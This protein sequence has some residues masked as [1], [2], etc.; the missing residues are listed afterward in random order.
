MSK[1]LT[2]LQ[3]IQPTSRSWSQWIDMAKYE[4]CC[5][6]GLSHEVQY[7]VKEMRNGKKKLFKRVR[8]NKGRTAQ[9]RKQQVFK[10][11]PV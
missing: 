3:F 6:C 11:R 8:V 1:R 2:K 10:C 4:L 9:W 7:A 5:D